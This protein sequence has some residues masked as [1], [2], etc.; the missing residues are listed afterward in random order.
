MKAYDYMAVRIPHICVVIAFILC[1]ALRLAF[2][3]SL[4]TWLIGVEYLGASG[5]VYVV[6]ATAST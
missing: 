4:G 2:A 1:F 3:W 6:Y 5:R